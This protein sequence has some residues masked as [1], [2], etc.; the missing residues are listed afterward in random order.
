PAGKVALDALNKNKAA[1]Q[2]L[3]IMM[4]AMPPALAASSAGLLDGSLSVS[5][6][7]KAAKG[8]GGEQAA[9]ALQ[10]LGLYKSSAGFSNILKTGGPAVQT[11]IGALGKAVGTSEGLSVALQLTGENAAGANKAIDAV[12]KASAQADGSIRGWDEVQHNFNQ[13]LAEAEQ[14]AKSFAIEA[15]QHLLPV[16]TD[17]L[18]YVHDHGPAALHALGTGFHDVEVVMSPFVSAA[19]GVLHVFQELPGPMKEAVVALVGLKVASSIGFFSSRG[20]AA[21]GAVGGAF[22]T[23]AASV[24]SLSSEMSVQQALFAAEARDAELAATGMGSLERALGGTAVAADA[25]GA[26]LTRVQMML[27]GYDVA[28]A[29]TVVAQDAANASLGR[30]GAGGAVL[31]ARGL[32]AVKSAGSGLMSMIGG[33]MGAAVITGAVAWGIY[34]SAEQ[35]TADATQKLVTALAAG[36]KAAADAQAQINT[37]LATHPGI[38]NSLGGKMVNQ[39]GILGFVQDL[40]PGLNGV[41]NAYQSEIKPAADATKEWQKQQSTMTTVEIGTHR[42]ADAQYHL[43]MALKN[44]NPDKVTAAY[45]ELERAQTYLATETGKE[46]NAQLT[47]NQLLEKATADALSARDAAL[48]LHLAQMQMND[49]IAQYNKDAHD[50]QHTTQQLAEEQLQLAQQ[51]KQ[52]AEQAAN[53]A[54]AQAKQ[55]G[56]TETGITANQAMLTSLRETAK[57]LTGPAHDAVMGM[58]HDLEKST[59]RA[60]IVREAM[61]NL[62]VTVNNL[63]NGHMIVI[64]APTGKQ[65]ADLHRL[66]RVT[67]TLPNGKVVVSADTHPAMAEIRNLLQYARTQA[68]LYRATLPSLVDNTVTSG[69]GRMGAPATGGW[70]S[71]PGTGTSDTAGVFA[72]SNREFVVNAAAA[73]ANGPLLEA[74]NGGAPVHTSGVAVPGY[75]SGGWIGPPGNGSTARIPVSIDHNSV[76]AVN[77]ALHA[78]LAAAAASASAFTGGGGGAGSAAIRALGMSIAASMGYGS[79]FGAIDYVFS[80]ESGWNPHAQNPTSTAYGIPQF[81]DSTWG[82]YGGKTS[83]A[84]QQIRDG[85]AYMR[86]RYGSPN[87]AASFW[88]AH[89][90]Y[91]QGGL[92]PP[93]PS[94]VLNGTGGTEHL[95]ILTNQQWDTMRVLATSER[96]AAMRTREMV[97]VGGGQTIVHKTDARSYPIAV[98]TSPSEAQILKGIQDA[99][100]ANEY[101]YG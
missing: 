47:Q 93:G 13:R 35:K 101:L 69:S 64:D 15:G 46:N 28:L 68:I 81:L 33:G 23:T 42:V 100:Y 3:V 22:K 66:G 20:T 25:A 95:G 62:G 96:P 40:I 10:F 14:G 89:H 38:E 8:L 82:P 19:G 80:R 56:A 43:A 51:A 16:L 76:L 24:A 71:G 4:K 50:G 11:Y 97:G 85:I 9:M 94:M 75:A 17:V 1:A 30:M 74:I 26:G 98:T 6:Y 54:V 99:Q 37:V 36:G 45:G 59:T 39:G 49:A 88:A 44:G 60:A 58:I 31:A 53:A 65:E 86:D 78:K 73:A 87:G 83:D 84:G 63:P 21:I 48:G 2:D 67:V 61:A 91:D 27:R 18:G 29:E 90:W 55:N 57:H 41:R 34:E 72:L 79:Q 7:T 32:S 52:V 92:V 70:I 5:A 77:S 12:A